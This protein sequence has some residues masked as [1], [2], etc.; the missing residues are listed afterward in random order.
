MNHFNSP[1]S[2]AALLFLSFCPRG[3]C[4]PASFLIPLFLILFL[5]ISFKILFHQVFLLSHDLTVILPLVK[6]SILDD[7]NMLSFCLMIFFI[8]PPFFLFKPDLLKDSFV[9]TCHIFTLIYSLA[10][11]SPYKKEH[12]KLCAIP[13]SFYNSYIYQAPSV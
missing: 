12:T 4:I 3:R 6:C 11:Y 9:F 8:P 1:P 10:F 5:S 7:V 2:T 13:Y